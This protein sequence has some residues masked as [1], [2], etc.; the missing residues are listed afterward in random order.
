MASRAPILSS[1]HEATVLPGVG[2]SARAL[3]LRLCPEP[4]N[5][6]EAD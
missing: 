3:S 2:L 4:G 1:F 5:E 6:L